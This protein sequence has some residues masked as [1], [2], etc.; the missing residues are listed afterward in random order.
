MK[1]KTPKQLVKDAVYA[2]ADLN[3]FAAVVALLEGGIVSADAQPDDFKIIA[4]AQRAQQRCL[5]RYD[6]AMNALGMPYGD[7]VAP[8]PNSETKRPEAE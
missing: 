1:K 5:S 8:P 3:A 2:H 6:R 7:M 4:M